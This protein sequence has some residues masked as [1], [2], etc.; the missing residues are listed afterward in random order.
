MAAGRQGNHHPTDRHGYCRARHAVVDR[1]RPI[2]TI[3]PD[4]M[5]WL[6]RP[7]DAAQAAS[8]R[9]C[10]KSLKLTFQAAPVE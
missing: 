5:K 4:L 9:R 2:L 7:E 3:A 10:R 6:H 1:E 8:E